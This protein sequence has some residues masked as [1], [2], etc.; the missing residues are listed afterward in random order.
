MR[1]PGI[2][3]KLAESWEGPYNV[4]K[5]NSSLSYR[6]DTGNR[7]IPFVH[8]QLLKQFREHLDCPKVAGVTSVFEP[9]TDTDGILDR[10]AEVNVVGDELQGKQAADV[11]LWELKHH[12]T[13]TKQ[14][15]LTPLVRFSI[16][17]GDHPPIYQRAYTVSSRSRKHD[18][19][20][21]LQKR[22]P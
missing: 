13:L 19:R 8:V 4:V 15:G 1:K 18:G 17:T 11:K 14:L 6:I 20:C 3:L 16:N 10:Y 21:T 22:A 5:C 9:D 12:E 7:T 2:N